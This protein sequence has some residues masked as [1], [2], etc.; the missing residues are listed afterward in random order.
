MM[1]AAQRATVAAA[2]LSCAVACA[3]QLSGVVVGVADGD[4]L[5]LLD[6]QHVQHRIRLAG[7]DAPEKG[8]DFGRVSRRSLHKLAHGQQAIAKTDKTDRYG[9]AVGKVM[10]HGQDVSIEQLRRGLAW[11]YK[12]YEREQTPQ[13]RL[14]YGEAENAAKGLQKGFWAMPGAMPPWEYRRQ[15]ARSVASSPISSPP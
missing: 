6:D 3:A 9:R 8:Q 7:T 1:V 14:A 10:V 2:L 12:A 4:T 5:T 13:D 15:H 11:H